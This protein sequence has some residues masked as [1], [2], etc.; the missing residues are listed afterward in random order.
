MVPDPLP[1]RNVFTRT[2]QFSFVREGIP[3]LA[4]KFGF[5]KDTPEAKIE[6]DWR[7]N[8]YHA[9]S[10]DLAQ[11]ILQEEEIKLDAFV[12][13]LAKTIADT[14]ERPIWLSTSIFASPKM[15][16]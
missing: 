10:D 2:D 7:A 16:Q 8:R 5:A 1:D 9:P 3:A 14:T 13:T 11:P 12:A 15:V 4:F 6:H